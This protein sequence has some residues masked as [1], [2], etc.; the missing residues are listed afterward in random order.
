MAKNFLRERNVKFTEKDV[1]RDSNAANEMVGRSGQMG[2]PVI[3]VDEEV[4]VG[5]DREKLEDI[6]ARQHPGASLSFGLKVADADRM[7]E[8]TGGV[9]VEGAFVGEVRGGSLGERAGLKVGDVIVEI[10]SMTVRNGEDMLKIV[11]GLVQGHPV[12]IKF[13]RSGEKHQTDIV[14]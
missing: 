5:F 4:I 9:S 8:K 10:N 11:S 7:A 1:S 14:L 12:S 2:V 6:L 3:M 13:I